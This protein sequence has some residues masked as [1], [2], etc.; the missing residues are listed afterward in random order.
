MHRHLHVL[1]AALLT[2]AGPVL[3][4]PALSAADAPAVTIR[5]CS[6]HSA[7][8]LAGAELVRYLGQMAGHGDAARIVDERQAAA[9]R[10]GLFA[11]CGV[12][13]AAV[14]DPARDDAIHV[15]VRESHGVI[16]GS[17]PRSVLFAAYRFLEGCGCRWIRPGK[18]GD[19]VPSHPVDHLSVRLDDQATYHFRGNNNCGT[20]S[21]DQILDK[22]AWAPKVGLNTFFSEFLLP[23]FL[24]NDYYSRKYATLRQ[25]EPRTDEELRAYHE[26]TIR[27]IKRRGLWYHAAGHGWTGL[28]VGCPESESDHRSKLAVP[29]EK[30]HYLALVGGKRVNNGPTF[31]D[32]CYGNPEVQKRLVQCVADYA[33]CHPEVDYLHVWQDDSMN[34]TCECE[35]C[36]TMRVSDWYLRILNQ[37]DAELTQRRIVTKIVFLIYQDLIWFPE[38]E[39]FEHPERFVMMYAPIS[40]RYGAPYYVGN[41]EVSL[42]PYELNKNQRPADEETGAAFLRGWQR[43]FRGEAFVFDYHMTW[44]HYLDPGYYGLLDVMGEDIRR[45]PAMHMDGFVSCQVLRSYFPHG[46]PMYAHARLL[47]NPRQKTDDLA[48]E[49]FGGSFGAGSEA[50]RQYMATL[51]RLFAPLHLGSDVLFGAESEAKRA[52]VANVARV[53]PTVADFRPVIDRGLSGPDAAQRQSWKYL[54]L[55]AEMV[56]KLAEAV[57]AKAAGQQKAADARWKEL[58]QMVA[59]RESETDAVLDIDWLDKSY[60][61]TKMFARAWPRAKPK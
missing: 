16:A 34:R 19:Y 30:E 45:L 59:E 7:V 23:R 21:L 51:S 61:R 29:P 26:L 20:Y 15:D 39:H 17:N 2:F 32:L 60:R 38:K 4:A 53:A 40:R 48:R 55:H 42:P 28:V 8:D 54:G 12:S 58:I 1:L 27:E 47:W 10:V 3:A 11:D 36:R 49:Y 22:I 5:V 56:L 46:F 35:V 24:Y 50:A 33:A 41:K 52:A 37:L 57:Q 6:R 31:T 14:K 13:L 43:L 18:D 9:I 44:H 25:G